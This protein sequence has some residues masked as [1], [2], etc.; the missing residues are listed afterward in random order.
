VDERPVEEQHV[1]GL[2]RHWNHLRLVRERN[3]DVG[4]ALAG[5]AGIVQ[6]TGQSWLRGTTSRQPFSVSHGSSAIHAATHVPGFTRR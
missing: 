2:H 1:S 3:R 5:A 6:R 4:E